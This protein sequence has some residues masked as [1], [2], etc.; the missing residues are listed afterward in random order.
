MFDDPL[1]NNHPNQFSLDFPDLDDYNMN[2]NINIVHSFTTTNIN[3]IR[4]LS[5]DHSL[6]PVMDFSIGF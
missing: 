4:Q 5:E 2:D 6:A 3:V 1:E